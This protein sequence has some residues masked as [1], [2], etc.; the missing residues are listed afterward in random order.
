MRHG[1]P[2]STNVMFHICKPLSARYLESLLQDAPQL[3][4][5]YNYII[6]GAGTAGSVLSNRLSA[7]KRASVL[8]IEAGGRCAIA[9]PFLGVTLPR[10]SV[11][12]NYTSTPQEGLNNRILQYAH[13][14]VLGGSSSINLMT[15][16][17]GSDDTWD[18]F[19]KITQDS[20]WSSKLIQKYYLRMSASKMD[21]LADGHDTTVEFDPSAHGNGPLEVSLP[22]F[23]T[24]LEDK[25][26]RTSQR[27]GGRFRRTVDLNARKAV[28]TSWMQSSIGHSKRITPILD[29]P[30]VGQNL[31]DQPFVPSYFTANSNLTFNS[32]LRNQTVFN[33]NLELGGS[34]AGP[35]SVHMEFIFIDGFGAFGPLTQPATRNFLTVASIVVSPLSRMY[36][37]F[38]A[39]RKVPYAP[40]SGG[41]LSLATTNPFDTGGSDARIR[42]WGPRSIDE[43]R[44]EICLRFSLEELEAAHAR[45]FSTIFHHPAVKAAEMLRI[46]D[47]SIFPVIPVVHTQA[48]VC[49]VAERDGDL[50]LGSL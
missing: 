47:A 48:A 32:V 5:Q 9:I 39:Y 49:T 30:S 50:I 20:G 13:G 16:N 21:P 38:T 17:R 45:K 11:D 27:L 18:R 7:I 41:N 6:V 4:S 12:W 31:T 2:S 37:I 26:F 46:V 33:A 15:W 29:L 36:L 23:P 44:S 34:S 42:C 3:R 24:Q 40:A 35:G 25:V 10:T 19:A 22:G 43:G 1:L 28:G 14:Y 8:V